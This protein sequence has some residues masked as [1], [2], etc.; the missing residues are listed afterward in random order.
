[1]KILVLILVISNILF[2]DVITFYDSPGL[3]DFDKV[4]IIYDRTNGQEK[5]FGCNSKDSDICTKLVST[6]QYKDG[7]LHGISRSFDQSGNMISEIEYKDGKRNGFDKRYD[8]QAHLIEETEWKDDKRNGFHKKYNQQGYLIEETEWKDDKLHGFSRVYDQE[9][10]LMIETEWKDNF[11]ADGWLGVIN[12]F[13]FVTLGTLF[14]KYPVIVF[15]IAFILNGCF[16]FT[17]NIPR[18]KSWTIF[19]P[20][21][22]WTLLWLLIM[23]P[24]SEDPFGQG[25]VLVF[26]SLFILPILIIITILFVL[27]WLFSLYK[28]TWSK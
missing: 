6:A 27:Y 22:A 21:L 8:Q 15:I 24:Q 11:R 25:L 28:Q 1:M 19:I 3:G 13:K 5:T 2:A 17:R 12:P 4:K 18:V 7:K 9:G 14:W 10:Q 20:S 23:S 16:I 26:T